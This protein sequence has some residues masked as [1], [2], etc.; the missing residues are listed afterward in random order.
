MKRCI[1]LLLMICLCA[2]LSACDGEWPMSIGGSDGPQTSESDRQ[3][4]SDTDSANSDTSQTCDH[5]YADATCTAPMTCKL[6]G[7]TEGTPKEHAWKGPFCN[8]PVHCG[9]CGYSESDELGDHEWREANCSSPITCIYCG[10]TEGESNDQHA[11]TYADC[12]KTDIC[13]LCFETRGEVQGDHVWEAASCT[14][15]AHCLYCPI[16]EGAPTGEH[17][18]QEAT[19][20]APKH[21]HTCGLSVGTATGEHSWVEAN[22]L[23]PKICTVCYLTEGEPNGI[24]LFAAA[25]CSSPKRCTECGH[26][27][28]EPNGEH[29]WKEADCAPK[30][31]LACHLRVGESAGLEH[32]WTGGSCFAS[33]QCST[34]G[35]IGNNKHEYNELFKCTL[36]QYYEFSYGLEYKPYGNGYQVVGRGSCTDTHVKIPETH[37]GKPVVSIGKKAFFLYQ[38][39]SE[40]TIPKSVT[41]IGLQALFDTQKIY[42][43][44]T[45]EDWIAIQKDESYTK[46]FGGYTPLPI[47]GNSLL[48]INGEPVYTLVIP[49]SITEIPNSAFAGLYLKEIVLHDKVTKIGKCAF[50][51]VTYP[52]FASNEPDENCY[53]TVRLPNSLKEIGAFAFADVNSK[54]MVIPESVE[55]I[56]VYA[57]TGCYDVYCEA[58][59]KP[60]L[61]HDE[62]KVP[63]VIYE[64]ETHQLLTTVCWKT[65][66]EYINGE[67]KPKS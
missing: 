44:S 53:V 39:A 10:Q 8:L 42:Y 18:W 3:D 48:H 59:E 50:T 35:L 64:D 41:H 14:R 9:V 29:I 15:P 37:D 38:A 31:C 17:L 49:E 26:C 61:W 55:T 24:H 43:Q 56:G 30:R 65:E 52:R 4:E 1:L 62:W 66:W 67:P 23:K 40:I 2:A 47:L 20:D 25:N 22:C 54:T 21:C 28:G 5:I 12:L 36:C 7:H 45:L 58:E 6:C 13:S 63:T 19:C 11:F 34:C 33:Q 16:I 51:M 32:T 57:F 27:E 60:A 46:D